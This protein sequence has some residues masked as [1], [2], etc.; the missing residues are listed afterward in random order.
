M[1]LTVGLEDFANKMKKL[2]K[3]A[4]LFLRTVKF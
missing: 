4:G 2:P 1:R 3:T